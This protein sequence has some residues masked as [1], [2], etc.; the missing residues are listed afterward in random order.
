MH[1]NCFRHARKK[2]TVS[3]MSGA[4]LIGELAFWMVI[5]N[6]VLGRGKGMLSVSEVDGISLI[7]ITAKRSA[8]YRT[9][10]TSC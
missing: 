4:G 6:V 7:K 5:L 10:C 8:A 1:S 3:G 2:F 9:L